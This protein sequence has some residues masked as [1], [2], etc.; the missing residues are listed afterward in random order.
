MS[1][2]IDR[3]KTFND[4]LGKMYYPVCSIDEKRVYIFSGY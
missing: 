4:T 3:R 1:L 2:D